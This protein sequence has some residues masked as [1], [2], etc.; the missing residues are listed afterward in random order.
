MSTGSLFGGS[1]T[2]TLYIGFFA[3][4][5]ALWSLSKGMNAVRRGRL[6]GVADEV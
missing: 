1:S 2:T 6:L 3:W 4:V 5:G